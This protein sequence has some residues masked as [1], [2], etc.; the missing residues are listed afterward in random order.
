MNR[1]AR[2]RQLYQDGTALVILTDACAM[3]CDQCGSCRR[4]TEGLIAQ[5]PEG[6]LLGELVLVRSRLRPM[7]LTVL[8]LLVL[9]IAGFFTGYWIGAVLWNAGKLT[10]CLAY[11]LCIGAAVIYDRHTAS[12]PGSGYTLI[13]YPQNINKG[14]NDID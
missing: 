3:E 5:N 10:G 1:Q 13:R 11:A 4:E 8:M 9:P 6:A 12:R 7:L 2:V 14:D